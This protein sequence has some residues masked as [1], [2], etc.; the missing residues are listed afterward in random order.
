MIAFANL[1][2]LGRHCS[3]PE[4][5]IVEEVEGPPISPPPAPDSGEDRDRSEL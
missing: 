1:A 2:S 5:H 4:D 3:I